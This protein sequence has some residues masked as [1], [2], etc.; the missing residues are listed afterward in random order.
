MAKALW[1]MGWTGAQL[2]TGAHPERGL[3]ECPLASIRLRAAVAALEWKRRGNES[4]FHVP[5]AAG[6]AR[7]FDSKDAEI[8]FVTKFTFDASLE[9]WLGA[10]RAAKQR[11]CRLVIDITDYPFEKRHPIP[12]FYA[13][14]LKICDAVVVNSERM[15]GMIAP[16]TPR[17]VAVIDDAILAEMGS[18][19]FAPGERLELLWFGHPTNLDFLE[20][21]FKDLARFARERRCRLTIVTEG[22]REAAQWTHEI[23]ARV[24][25]AFETQFI[26][27]SLAAMSDALRACDLVLIPGDPADPFKAGASANR[28]AEALNAG[29]FPVASPLQSY[30]QFADAAW[31]GQDLVAGIRWALAN[32]DEVLARARR[33][34]ALIREK[35][36][37]ERIGREWHDLFAGLLSAPRP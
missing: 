8:C 32:G 28:I 2:A 14:A 1:L 10:C 30:L 22:G 18:P 19:Q 21:R 33:G 25:Y 13:E 35:F 37:A 23:P 3:L 20:A 36:A 26:P 6:D 15:A 27:W 9:P 11:H 4:R 16:H 24:G 5:D 29:R 12:A 17:R 34:Q 31:L 7:D